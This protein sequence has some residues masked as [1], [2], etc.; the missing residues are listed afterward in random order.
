MTQ[1][2][3]LHR[4]AWRHDGRDYQLLSLRAGDPTRFSVEVGEWGAL[5]RSDLAGARLLGRLLWGLAYQRRPDTLLVLDPEHLVPDPFDGSPSP[6]VVFGLASSTVLNARVAR[7]LRQPALWRS[8]PDG[9]VGWNTASLP[10]AYAELNARFEARRAGLPVPHVYTPDHPHSIVL[11]AGSV[12]AV[13]A[14]PEV[15]RTWAVLVSN[16]GSYWY[17]GEACTEPSYGAPGIDVHAV[18]HFQRLVSAAARARA[19]VVAAPDCPTDPADINR[20]VAG[21]ALLVA[22]RNP[23]P[24][25]A[26]LRTTAGLG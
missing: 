13:L 11:D 22:A 5:I 9:T 8:R 15:F 6:V 26:E 21:N 10:E 17:H 14:V 7:R 24:W 2:I 25:D 18:R 16:A 3:R 1:R 19:E 23:G 20:R 12:F 4:R